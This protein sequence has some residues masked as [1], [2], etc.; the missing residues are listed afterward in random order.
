MNFLSKMWRT[1]AIGYWQ[2]KLNK[3]LH[4]LELL[5]RM[6]VAGVDH[7]YQFF[8][9]HNPVYRRQMNTG[10]KVMAEQRLEELGSYDRRADPK[11]SHDPVLADG[12]LVFAVYP[13]RDVPGDH[14]GRC[15]TIDL[16][17]QGGSV[18]STLEALGEMFQLSTELDS[19]SGLDFRKRGS[20]PAEC[21]APVLEQARRLA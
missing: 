20:A 9:V 14:I 1:L 21:W 8:L 6:D 16:V 4:W 3:A 19:Q 5:D 2:R 7:H 17:T 11:G 13:C 10:L 15:L 12:F 18:G